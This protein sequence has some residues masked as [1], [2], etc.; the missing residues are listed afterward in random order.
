ME[1]QQLFHC[2]NISGHFKTSLILEMLYSVR[3]IKLSSKGLEF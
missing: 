3:G 2:A 1:K